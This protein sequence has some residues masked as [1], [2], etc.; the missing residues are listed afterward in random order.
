MSTAVNNLSFLLT[1]KSIAITGVSSNP[2]D[3]GS[4]ILRNIIMGG[5]EGKIY[6]ISQKTSQ[7]FDFDTYP[8]IRDIR[9]EVDLVIIANSSDIVIDDV[10]D[11]TRGKVKNIC[12]ASSGFAETGIGGLILQKKIVK[13]A[14]E[15]GIRVL[16]P[17][18]LGIISPSCKL[19][20]T[21]GPAV[22]LDD[23]V[24]KCCFVSQSGALI[25]AFLEYIDF[26][27]LGVENIVS[28]GNKADI[29]E[30]DLM[31]YYSSLRDDGK[32][33]VLGVYLENI[34]N[35]KEFI[36]IGTKFTDKIPLIVLIP[37]ESPK[38]KEYIY[39]HSG[40]IIQRDALIDLALEKCGAIKVYTQ[41]E[42]F[43]LCLAFS[44]QPLPRGNK[45]AVISNAG[46]GLILAIEQI[47]RKGLKLVN[48]STEIKRMLVTELDWK[49]KSAGIVDL[50]GQAL[51]ISYL[52]ALDIVLGDYDVNA[53]LIIL[54]PQIMTQIEETAETIGRLSRQ[55]GKTIIA[56]FMGYKGV[57]K[58]ISALSKYF[59][60]TFNS[61]D[62][63]VLVL[64]KMYKY[65]VNT[66][67][68]FSAVTKFSY[69]KPIEKE[70]SSEILE[71]IEKAR[72]D[73][74]YK[75]NIS[76]CSSILQNYDVN[77]SNIQRVGSFAE[78]IDFGSEKKYPIEFFCLAENKGVVVYRKD[79]AQAAFEN[80][81]LRKK[82]N[83]GHRID[84]HVV[85]KIY[86]GKKKF[87]IT[88]VK[89]T[90]YEHREKG[91]SLRELSNLS[92]GYY[93][94]LSVNKPQESKK[95]KMLLPL[96]REILDWEIQKS[97]FFWDLGIKSI[98]K[99]RNVNDELVK[100]IGKIAQIPQDFQ[101]ILS[102]EVECIFEGEKVIVVD[103]RIE[104][105]MV[106]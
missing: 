31:S 39:T 22:E 28:L 60:P 21:F 2:E 56:A 62:R 52:K 93:F 37:S 6:P 48:F 96:S 17:N 10:Y 69:L 7:L 82:E 50:G 36:E 1:P 106:L 51:S 19:N 75:L 57:E 97:K 18:S 100:V 33:S 8:R 24:G 14:S 23:N 92:F 66:Q 12:I 85:K 42:L 98:D 40:S 49:G 67:K 72:I 15:A 47:Y 5:F 11:S 68:D 13:M 16:G 43:D 88:I 32:P 53:V 34:A 29:N 41:Q 55:H 4:Y 87:K 86:S 94:E 63:A 26:Y 25:N 84:D 83:I 58:G 20:A 102:L 61:V 44:W 103:C 54:S 90:Y 76:E 74:R 105:D 104:L 64:S 65:F 95:V 59:I 70:R 99:I 79:Q 35:G 80:H 73:K 78:V 89:D 3:L 101:Q 71:T 81:F 77:M 38:T 45:V 9:E 30:I 91:F 46:G 27:S